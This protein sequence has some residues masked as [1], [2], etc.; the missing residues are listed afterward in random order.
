MK[1]PFAAEIQARHFQ[2][3]IILRLVFTFFPTVFLVHDEAK[4]RT[5]IPGERPNKRCMKNWL[6]VIDITEAADLDIYH[7]HNDCVAKTTTHLPIHCLKSVTLSLLT[8][9][10]LSTEGFNCRMSLLPK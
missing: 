1:M 7:N 5:L 3:K 2:I 9:A 8:N 10:S 4:V 6:S